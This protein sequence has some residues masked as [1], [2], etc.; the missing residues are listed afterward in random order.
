LLDNKSEIPIKICMAK[1]GQQKDPRAHLL[2]S[3]C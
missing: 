2:L 1:S 3:I